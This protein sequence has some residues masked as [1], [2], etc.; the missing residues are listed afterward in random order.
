MQ[1][2]RSNLQCSHMQD[3]SCLIVGRVKG[4]GRGRGKGGREGGGG[5]EVREGG[6]DEIRFIIIQHF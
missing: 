6:K 2:S 3:L 4:E 5:R 1:V